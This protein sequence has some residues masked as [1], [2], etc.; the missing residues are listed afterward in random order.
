METEAHA[1]RWGQASFSEVL[2][3]K[4]PPKARLEG[5][6]RAN[7]TSKPR[8]KL[9][10]RR[11]Q[12]AAECARSP[13]ARARKQRVSL[14]ARLCGSRTV[15]GV[16]NLHQRSGC[17]ESVPVP[18]CP[19]WAGQDQ[20]PT[21]ARLSLGP[22]ES[23]G[24]RRHLESARRGGSP[25]GAPA[26][27]HPLLA[28]RRYLLW[29]RGFP[30]AWADA[31]SSRYRVQS[32]TDTTASSSSSRKRLLSSLIGRRSSISNAARGLPM[33]LLPA[34]RPNTGYPPVVPARLRRSARRTASLPGSFSS[35]PPAHA[36][37]AG[38][39]LGRAG[40]SQVFLRP[41]NRAPPPQVSAP[42]LSSSQARHLPSLFSFSLLHA[43]QEA[44]LVA[45]PA[46]C[47]LAAVRELSA[48]SITLYPTCPAHVL[49]PPP[50]A[51][52]PRP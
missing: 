49:A 31:T 28:P 34:G 41:Q 26:H 32:P 15:E 11:P 36:R 38:V 35:R 43:A 25:P 9:G 37:R 44:L 12:R 21:A 50:G 1:R 18:L 47:V 10:R 39:I 51:G 4:E 40:A 17:S 23:A 3:E 8:A 20:G 13:G 27:L 19:G 7:H 16:P 33:A 42:R 5:K 30:P 24:R 48:P 52:G 22:G 6:Q 2:F 45:R 46:L 29:F 14:S